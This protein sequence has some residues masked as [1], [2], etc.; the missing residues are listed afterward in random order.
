M[1]WDF[2]TEATFRLF[3]TE[4]MM[5]RDH[6]GHSFRIFLFSAH[7]QHIV[8]RVNREWESYQNL[9]YKH[10]THTYSISVETTNEQTKKKL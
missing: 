9:Y 4:R 6:N 10:N 5:Q 3:F 2:G 8:D 1:Y 7:I